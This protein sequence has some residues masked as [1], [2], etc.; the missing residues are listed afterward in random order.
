MTKRKL[1]YYDFNE[2]R[3]DAH[4]GQL[5]KDEKSIILTQKS[6]EILL[7]FIK[8][9]GRVLRKKEL[10]AAIWS[11]AF[12]EESTLSQHIYM[13]R[14]AL[15]E[16]SRSEL[17]IETV[18]KIGYRFTGTVTEIHEDEIEISYPNNFGDLSFLAEEVTSNNNP[19]KPYLIEFSSSSKFK[20]KLA[21]ALLIV[22]MVSVSCFFFYH[23]F[24]LISAENSSIVVLPFQQING[25]KD[26]N[27][28]LGMA[29]NII[30]HL[31]KVA[32]TR[33]TPTSSIIRYTEGQ[34][35][36]MFEIGE[37][38]KADGVVCG[39]VQR[40]NDAVRVTFQLYC[41]KSK[42]LLMSETIDGKYVDLFSIQDEISEKILKFLST[43]I[44]E[45]QEILAGKPILSVDKKNS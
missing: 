45:E 30:S 7:F 22:L 16:N 32:N 18:P 10:L 25:R 27:L 36:E 37:K 23:R 33:V 4:N 9:R 17:P 19:I 15:K 20:G 35:I 21:L 26:D 44:K 38:F 1:L 41:T 39:T 14:K 29:D 3:L 2:F 5:F 12:V 34:E 11:E 31:G 13:L 42:H 6:F 8:N 28:G 43:K 40:D 24:V